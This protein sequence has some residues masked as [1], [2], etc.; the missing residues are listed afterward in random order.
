MKKYILFFKIYMY[1]NGLK[2]D[3]FYADNYISFEYKEEAYTW[4]RSG[5]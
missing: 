3:N 1:I 4:R 5:G 2:V